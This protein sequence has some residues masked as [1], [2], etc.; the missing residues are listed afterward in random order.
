MADIKIFN[1]ET[2]G[3]PL[4]QYGHVARVKAAEYLFIAGQ[5]ATDRDG[6]FV[7]AG[8]FEAQC[9]QV[10]ANIGAA[11]KSAGA[12]FRNVVQFTTYLVNGED[13]PKLRAYRQREFGKLFPNEIYPPN[14]LLIIDRLVNETFLI[15]VQ[16]VAAL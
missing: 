11:L 10:Y 6:N 7:G 13:I 3:K 16:T 5:V 2:L 15:E 9:A 4:G 14:T 1:P 12:D 8:D